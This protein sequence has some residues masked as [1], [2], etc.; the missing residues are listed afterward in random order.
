[1]SKISVYKNVRDNSGFA[2]WDIADFLFLVRHELSP[3]VAQYR[4]GERD[5]KDIP[6]VT[7]SGV[8]EPTRRKENLK[9]HSGFI[10]VDIDNNTE[11]AETLRADKYTYALFKSVSGKGLCVIVRL[12]AGIETAEEH[13]A[14]AR[15]L[16]EYYYKLYSIEVDESCKDVTRL[17]I[18]SHDRDLYLNE[19]AQVFEAKKEIECPR[20]VNND[21]LPL[22]DSDIERIERL[23]RLIEE[24]EIDIC[25]SY[26]DWMRL[27]F[28]FQRVPNGRDFFERI[29]YIRGKVKPDTQAADPRK[30]ELQFER[31]ARY[32]PKSDIGTFFYLCKRRGLYVGRGKKNNKNEKMNAEEL[33]YDLSNAGDFVEYTVRL[34]SER[35]YFDTL[36]QTLFIDNKE[37]DEVAINSVWNEIRR[38]YPKKKLD[39]SIVTNILYSNVV[40][41]VDPLA[42]L[43]DELPEPGDYGMIK[44]LAASLKTKY[45]IPVELYLRKF[46]V[47]IIGG[48]KAR[49]DSPGTPCAQFT[50]VLV[51]GPGLGKTYFCQNLLPDSFKE[52]VAEIAL[53]GK[54]TDD[55]PV[56]F[57]N[58]LV[59]IDEWD[60]VKRV[61][62]PYFRNLITMK[63]KT[64][65]LSYR[66]DPLTYIRR[67]SIIGTSNHIDLIP[68]PQNNRRI[69]P[70]EVVDIDHDLYNSVDK[71]LLLAEAMYWYNQGEVAQISSDDLAVFNT[72][73]SPYASLND[74]EIIVKEHVM[75]SAEFIYTATEIAALIKEKYNLQVSPRKVSSV[76]KTYGYEYTEAR[77]NT[78]KK[79]GFRVELL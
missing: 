54:P 27:S 63:D 74:V 1:M 53:T 19:K 8:F 67:A 40:R 25:D 51:G 66:R 33:G 55:Y 68:D 7:V 21:P 22:G 2:V 57:N 37:A 64:V 73:D 76:L 43:L 32:A 45:D 58:L 31:A 13:E 71:T 18:L 44:Q 10:A 62:A 16:F 9:H 65:R 78:V 12:P 17:R 50:P 69:V 41:Q 3:E 23:V 42:E 61:P 75:P 4:R 47:G 29:S 36:R 46:L 39:K 34:N 11:V 60:S 77:I 59:V 30:V 5:K 28:A 15:A 49:R 52:F 35:F 38:L 14:Y 56:M 48:M 20:V 26:D 70:I 72:A 24:K 79:K 6:A